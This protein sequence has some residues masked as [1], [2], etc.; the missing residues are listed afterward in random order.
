MSETK[1]TPGPWTWTREDES[2]T[3]LHGACE[4]SDHVLS[5]TPCENCQ[6]HN[7]LCLGPS[8]ANAHLLASAP[9]LYAALDR[10]EDLL[11]GWLIEGVPIQREAVSEIRATVAI[12]LSKA[13]GEDV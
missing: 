13:R 9:D 8:P 5:V 10:C 11:A 6:K 12:A 7:G 2:M 1:C 3:S 4:F